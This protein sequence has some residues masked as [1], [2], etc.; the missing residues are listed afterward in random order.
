MIYQ[1]MN[2]GHQIP[3]LGTG[4][5]TYGKMENDYYGDIN[6]DTTELESA[7]AAGYRSIDTAVS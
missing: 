7:I 1:T 3:I 2:D 4:T 5:N 6:D